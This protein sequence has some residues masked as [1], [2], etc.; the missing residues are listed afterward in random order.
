MDLEYLLYS[1][2]VTKKSSRDSKRMREEPIT[3][4]HIIGTTHLDPLC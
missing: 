1:P 3:D 4:I 2:A